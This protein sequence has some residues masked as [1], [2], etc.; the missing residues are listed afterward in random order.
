MLVKGKGE[1]LEDPL[2]RLTTLREDD[3]ME[4]GVLDNELSWTL[5][6]LRILARVVGPDS[7][8][9]REHVFDREAKLALE[10]RFELEASI[11]TGDCRRQPLLDESPCTPKR[12]SIALSLRVEG[13]PVEGGVQCSQD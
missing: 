13:L 11:T 5:E 4:R 10:D 7:E 3:G 9:I 8:A 12:V 2:A 6:K 1:I